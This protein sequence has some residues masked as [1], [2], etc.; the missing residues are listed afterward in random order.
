MNS[1]A[2]A[3][4]TMIRQVEDTI[5]EKEFEH[6]LDCLERETLISS[7]NFLM[8]KDGLDSKQMRTIMKEIFKQCAKNEQF[9]EFLGN[10]MLLGW[11]VFE[12]D[13]SA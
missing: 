13:K 12:L 9:R 5:D 1:P 2:L 6:I 7:W 10:S 4:F 11:I 3:Y 8:E